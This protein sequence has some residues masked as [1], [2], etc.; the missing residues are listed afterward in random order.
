MDSIVQFTNVEYFYGTNKAI[1]NISFIVEKGDFVALVGHNGSGKST[2]IKLLLGIL[3]ANSGSIQLFN[4]PI[5]QFADWR[6]VGYLPQSI[7]FLNPLFP[8]TVKEVVSL[9][10]L[11]FKTFPKRITNIDN[12]AI[13]KAMDRMGITNLSHKL[14][15][16]L[17]G[18][19]IQRTLLARAIVNEPELLILDEPVSAVDAETREEFFSYTGELKKNKKTT[20][21]LITHDIGHSGGFANKLLFLDRHIVFYGS[22]KDF[23]ISKSMK[24]QFGEEIQHIVCHQHN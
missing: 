2:V 21:I 12:E 11:S 20:M 8:A 1:D 15:G 6:K 3:T 5:H 14:I 7:S 24:D 22:F 17:S 4:T 13:E 16:E 10:L 9:G 23:C 19:Q 18:G